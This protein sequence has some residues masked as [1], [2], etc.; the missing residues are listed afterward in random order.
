[1][2]PKIET[3]KIIKVIE[4]YN[5]PIQAVCRT[6]TGLKTY[7]LKYSR[8]GSEG[9]GLFSELICQRLAKEVA[10]LTPEVALVTI[11]NHDVPSY[12]KKPLPYKSGMVTFGS[13][14]VPNTEPLSLTNISITNNYLNKLTN[15]IDLFK[16][17]LF[18]FWIGNTDRKGDNFN[19]LLTLT[20]K[21][22]FYVFDH[23]LA[24]SDITN[25]DYNR[26][27]V[28]NSLYKT[29]LY[30]DF[31]Y[32]LLRLKHLGDYQNITDDFVT[33]VRSLD[34]VNIVETIY[35]QLP[36]EWNVNVDAKNYIIEYLTNNDRLN[37]LHKLGKSY[38]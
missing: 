8:S 33:T 13:L 2:L 6:D 18:D 17:G 14:E 15:P 16:I 5:K 1:M 24:F 27:N 35:N 10:L 9:D 30:T 22:Q 36:P 34:I 38:L 20:H 26:I 11:G 23:F 7:F 32:R 29:L 4:T 37:L 12:F 28:I 19:L 3:V 25:H 21:R 31:V